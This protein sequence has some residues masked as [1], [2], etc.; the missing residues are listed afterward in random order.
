MK[1]S[2]KARTQQGELQVGTIEAMNQ[3][4]AVSAL[5]G[6]G[7]FVLSVESNKEEDQWFDR[8]LNFFKRVKTTDLMI[9]TRQ[10]STLLASQVALSDALS[11]LYKQTE[12]QILKE[13]ISE[14]TQDVQ[15]GFSL[16][17]SF[18]RHMNI[19][20]EFYVN[21]VRSAEATGRLSET[22]EF[23][24]NYIENQVAMQSKIKNAL[25]YP[26]FMVVLAFIVLGIMVMF[27]FPQIIPILKDSNV[28]IPWYTSVLIAVGT[29]LGTWWWAMLFAL[30]GGG[31]TLVNYFQTKEG[32]IVFDETV[33]RLPILGGLFK[34]IYV[35]RFAES[36]RVLIKGGLT[37]PQAVEIT[38]RTIGS[39]VYGEVLTRVSEEVRK[40]KLLSKAM[41]ENPQFPPLISQLVAI[42]EST[43]RLEELLEKARIFY[44]REV[45]SA[46]ENS[47][48]L[49]Q[50]I[51]MIFIGGV[52]AFLFAG[53]LFPLFS[54]TQSI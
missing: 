24:A 10:F 14:I 8:I 17:Q 41:E 23:L 42:G 35:V 31:L 15:A 29:F 11:G 13:A 7:L 52:V 46:I 34:R 6:H 30:G 22:L 18:E 44:A 32:R 50:P 3:D 20:S 45:D 21:M 25:T 40:G 38:S 33:L 16:S 36:T 48:A 39:S 53:I 12:N 49:I 47:V 5:L 9:F 54:L 4:A 19:F 37:I 43:G 1:F 28:E 2:Y 51:L 26:I 27:V